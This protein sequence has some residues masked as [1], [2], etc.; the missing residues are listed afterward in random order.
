MENS[1]DTLESYKN[2]LLKMLVDF[3][4]IC[5]KFNIKY[6]LCYGTL[7]GAVRHRGFIPW[8]D[9]VDIMMPRPDYEKLI[10]VR[11]L[12][13]GRMKIITPS[14]YMSGY[15]WHV[16]RIYDFSTSIHRNINGRQHYSA[17]WIDVF[18]ID[19][20]FENG[21]FRAL[22]WRIMQVFF[23]IF[24]LKFKRSLVDR[25]KSAF[26]FFP[27]LFSGFEFI[28]KKIPVSA[29][30]SVIDWL[31]SCKKY[32]KSEYVGSVFEM[33]SE[34]FNKASMLPF[35]EVE[36]EG[37]FFPAPLDPDFYLK[38]TYGDYMSLPPVEQRVNHGITKINLNRPCEFFGYEE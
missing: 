22:R 5:K 4:A 33:P 13:P 8:D 12:M 24:K 14:D 29:L 32:N 11:D 16:T 37:H 20:Q 10:E 3:D 1:E 18:P 15:I 31:E 2:H 25:Y 35:S 38:N 19:G 6:C 9:D 30:V 17:A 23:F 34:V 26:R 36:F 7:L 21:F 27:S 28:L